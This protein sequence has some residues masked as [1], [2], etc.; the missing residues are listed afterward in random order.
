MATEYSY[1]DKD[2]LL[3]PCEGHVLQEN[4]QVIFI[5]LQLPKVVPTCSSSPTSTYQVL[6][7]LF[8]L[9]RNTDE[10]NYELELGVICMEYVPSALK[11]RGTTEY[12]ALPTSYL[13]MAQRVQM[14][15]AP[16][17]SISI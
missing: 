4:F 14:M 11:Y 3:A 17:L 5:P 13:C 7:R 10:K 1:R 15:T 6:D 2:E 8:C 16:P 12:T 9:V